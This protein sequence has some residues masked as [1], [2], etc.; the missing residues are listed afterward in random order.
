[1][2]HLKLVRL[3]CEIIIG[4]A[5]VTVL[6]YVISLRPRTSV[7]VLD[8]L[9]EACFAAAEEDFVLRFV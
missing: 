2:L 3:T 4:D 6:V 9:C 1:M 7:T 5:D 8:Y